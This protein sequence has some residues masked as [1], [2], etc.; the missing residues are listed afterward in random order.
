MKSVV[1]IVQPC[2]SLGYGFK[3]SS[4]H[5]TLPRDD[6]DRKT[7]SS[8]E[9]GLPF[10]VDYSLVAVIFLSASSPIRDKTH[11]TSG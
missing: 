1:L 4:A 7:R 5:P 11:S 2:H 3:P 9:V 6:S 8:N 10:D